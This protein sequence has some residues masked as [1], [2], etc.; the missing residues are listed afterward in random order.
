[1][2]LKIARQIARLTQIELAQKAGVD[3]SAISMVESG[4]REIGS[5]SYAAV[6]RIARVLSPQGHVEELFPIHVEP[7]VAPVA[8]EERSA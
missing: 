6:V 8:A 2:E 3:N 1:M 4:K 5:M 7:V